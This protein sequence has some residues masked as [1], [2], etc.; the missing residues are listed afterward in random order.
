MQKEMPVGGYKWFTKINL[1][2]ILSTPADSAFGYFGE[3]HLAYPAKVQDVH[4]DLPLP[5]EK[6][7]DSDRVEI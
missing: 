6:T 5:T 3:V 2:Q 1:S 7:E 4:N